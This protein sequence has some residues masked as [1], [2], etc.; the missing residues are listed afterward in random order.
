MYALRKS[1]T[2]DYQQGVPSLLCQWISGAHGPCNLYFNTAADL[3]QHISE[4]H[5]PTVRKDNTRTIHKCNWS[6]CKRS[7]KVFKKRD[8]LLTHCK[9]HLTYPKHPC[10]ECSAQFKW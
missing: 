1:Q 4:V 10:G 5:V 8:Q 2:V 7:D 6:N 3:H 9:S